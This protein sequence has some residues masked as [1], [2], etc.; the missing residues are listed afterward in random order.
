MRTVND[1][2]EIRRLHRDGL[3]ARQIA[4]QLGV[5]RDTVRKAL[6]HPEPIPYTL[7]TPR[8]APTFGPVRALVDAILAA[9]ES[10]PR[11]QRHTATQIYRR[12]VAEHGYTGSYHPIQ[13]HLKDRRLAARETF[14]PLAHSPGHRCEA[15]FGHIHVDFPDGRRLVPVLLVTWSYSNAPFAIALPTERTEAVLHGLCEAF[16]FFG[17]VPKELW[18]DNPTTVAIHIGRGRERTLHPRYAALGSHYVF[19]AKFCLP[20]TPQEKPRVENRVKD[21]QRMWATPVPRVASLA[22]LNT[23]LRQCCVTT[24]SRTCGD[25]VMSVEERFR[26]DQAAALPVPTRRFEACVIHPG[27]ADKYQT[28][29][30]DGNR[31]SVPRRWA[32]R[33]VTVKGFIDHIEI[34]ADS[35]VIATHRRSYGTHEK[36][37][38]PRHFLVVLERKPAALDHA[39]VYRD[40]QLPPAFAQLRAELEQRLGSRT[41][42]RHFIRI[43]QLLAHHPLERVERAILLVRIRGDPDAAKITACVTRLASD[44]TL[45]LTDTELSLTPSN[46]PDLARFNQLLSTHPQP[47]TPHDRSEHTAAESQPQASQTADDVG[48]TRETGPRRGDP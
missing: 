30:F 46:L 22:E 11:K 44:S 1:F 47:E 34:V 41:G 15:D 24:R 2:A 18:W 35:R 7:A 48:R 26:Q 19:A 42:V 12:L 28:V 13:R 36:V 29:A 3:S 16:A 20:A 8:P 4:R 38:D 40:W 23:H 45:S 27:A 5:G 37:L 17:C 39:P 14:I 9:D 10:A 43:L 6:H 21:L 31:Y 25:N 32:F 33:T